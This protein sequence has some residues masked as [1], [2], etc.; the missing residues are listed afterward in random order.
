MKLQEFFLFTVVF[1]VV[2]VNDVFDSKSRLYVPQFGELSSNICLLL[3]LC[4]CSVLRNKFFLRIF[5]YLIRSK[6][7][8]LKYLLAFVKLIWLLKLCCMNKTCSWKLI[9]FLLEIQKCLTLHTSKR[10][11]DKNTLFNS[12][13]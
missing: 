1:I 5:Y 3:F 12:S 10:V 7:F 8:S 9:Y 4:S 6:A 2:F 11:N 13:C